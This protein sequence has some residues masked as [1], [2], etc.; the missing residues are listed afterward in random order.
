MGRLKRLR[1]TPTPVS[2][3]I[4]GALLFAV[5]IGMLAACSAW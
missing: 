4:V 2:A 3:Y 5:G 1:G